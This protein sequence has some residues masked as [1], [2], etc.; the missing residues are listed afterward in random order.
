MDVVALLVMDVVALVVMD[1][2]AL[3]VMDVVALVVMDIVAGWRC[4]VSSH[5]RDMMSVCSL[6]GGYGTT[7]LWFGH[8]LFS[9]AHQEGWGGIPS[10]VFALGRHVLW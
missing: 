8:L 1:V 7:F 9:L 5:C 6:V 4:V 2:V 3:L 10:F